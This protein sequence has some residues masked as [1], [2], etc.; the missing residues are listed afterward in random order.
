M[1]IDGVSRA[2]QKAKQHRLSRSDADKQVINK[3]KEILMDKH[4]MTEPEAH[5][6]L[7]KCS[8]ESGCNMVEAAEMV[9]SLGNM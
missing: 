8:M 3:A 6:Y 2:R 5:K 7:Q 9:L 1:M 4:H